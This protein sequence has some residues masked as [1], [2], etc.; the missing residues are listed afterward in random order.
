MRK[1]TMQKNKTLTMDECFEM[2]I[3][4]CIIRNLSAQTVKTYRNHYSVFSKSVNGS[5][6]IKNVTAA[7]IDDFILHLKEVNQCNDI[8]INSYLRTI[9]TFLYSMMEQ[10]YLPTFKINKLKVDKSIN[11]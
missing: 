8:S 1:I 9:R 2:F 3:K 4:R 7:T 6:P 11:R 10:D 5:I